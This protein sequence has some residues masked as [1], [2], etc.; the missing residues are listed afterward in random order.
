MFAK[1]G[2]LGGGFG[3]G[4]PNLKEI[5]VVSMCCIYFI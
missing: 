5:K 4:R 3:Y 1:Q 2:E